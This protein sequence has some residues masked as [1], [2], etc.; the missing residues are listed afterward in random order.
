MNKNEI[1]ELLNEGWTMA[2]IEKGY[3]VFESEDIPNALIIEKIDAVNK[4]E[5]D[6]EASEQAEKDGIAI[7]RDSEFPTGENYIDTLENQKIIENWLSTHDWSY[8]NRSWIN[9]AS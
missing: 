5:T 6:T 2:Q 7:I 4:F 1:Q 9:K 3:D 8:I